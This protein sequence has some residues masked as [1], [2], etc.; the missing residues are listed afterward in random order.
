MKTYLI[1]EIS[2][3]NVSYE[4]VLTASGDDYK[5]NGGIQSSDNTVAQ[6]LKWLQS[7]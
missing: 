2:V 3:M 6:T 1:P 4:D 5:T 7:R